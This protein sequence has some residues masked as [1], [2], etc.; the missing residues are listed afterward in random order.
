MKRKVLIFG[1]RFD[2]ITKSHTTATKYVLDYM[3]KAP[4]NF[5][6]VWFL[7]S[8]SKSHGDTI[9][10]AE[11]RVEM[12]ELALSEDEDPRMRISTFELEIGNGAGAYSVIRNLINAYP[13]YTFHYLV[14][15][16]QAD[17]V[18]KWRN[19]RKLTNMIPFVVI[20]RHD[21]YSDS[22]PCW[23]WA[24]PHIHINI[25]VTKSPMYAARVRE[26]Y[27]A[28]Y[29]AKHPYLHES[30]S[31]YILKNGIYKAPETTVDKPTEHT[32]VT[33]SGTWSTSDTKYY[34]SV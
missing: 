4:F 17:V 31:D 32:F 34:A 16:D 14:G 33:L 11:Q 9:A 1:G 25:Y 10:S 23:F 30:V 18:R 6:Q 12:I 29:N 7:P 20:N 15:L 19:S 27:R 22:H 24:A 28:G 3:Q 13:D 2:P 26:D 5:E 21:Y 8:C